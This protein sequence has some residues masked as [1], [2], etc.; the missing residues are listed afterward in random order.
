MK[1]EGTWGAEKLAVH[2]LPTSFEEMEESL[3][4]K[5]SQDQEGQR[6]DATRLKS[7]PPF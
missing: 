5:Q 7:L 6:N 2:D 3:L 1:Q 4:T